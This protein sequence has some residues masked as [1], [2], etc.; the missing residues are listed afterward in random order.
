MYCPFQPLNAVCRFDLPGVWEK[1]AALQTK[2]NGCSSQ[3]ETTHAADRREERHGLLGNGLPLLVP[4]RS[5]PFRTLSTPHGHLQSN[6]AKIGVLTS[7]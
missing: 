5:V 1:M 2:E 6:P 4:R 7:L 3:L